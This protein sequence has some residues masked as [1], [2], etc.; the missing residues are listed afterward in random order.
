MDS[1]SISNLYRKYLGREAT[2]SDF[3]TLTTKGFNTP[4]SIESLLSSTSK[5]IKGQ[6]LS[7]IDQNIQSLQGTTGGLPPPKEMSLYGGQISDYATF[8]NQN[9][10]LQQATSDYASTLKNVGFLNQEAAA[11]PDRT[12]SMLKAGSVYL[13]ESATDLDRKFGDPKSPWF[14]P[15]PNMRQKIVGEAIDKRNETLQ[16]V[17]TKI[18]SVYET[19]KE[20]AG[21]ELA[22]QKVKLDAATKLVEKTYDT[23]LGYFGERRAEE[24]QSRENALDR[25]SR[26]QGP[27][28]DDVE[29]KFNTDVQDEVKN[30]LAGVYGKNGSRES[31]ITSLTAKYPDKAQ[32]IKDLIYG[33]AI[34][35]RTDGTNITQGGLLPDGYEKQIQDLTKTYTPVSD[36]PF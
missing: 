4:Q 23:L 10:Q 33:T 20:A 30:V 28:S 6:T 26:N 25:A 8:Q 31:A 22:G 11:Q 3:K 27:S 21:N 17:V 36:N 15:D 16:D 13:G 34:G 19:M 18:S 32:Q 9:P 14:V 29:T 5:S 2:A 35:Q 7:T 12:R 1:T 24:F